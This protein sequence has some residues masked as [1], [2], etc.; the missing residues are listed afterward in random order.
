MRSLN[1]YTSTYSSSPNLYN[2][3][4]RPPR[5]LLFA[6]SPWTPQSCTAG[7]TRPPGISW[8]RI[9]TSR[10]PRLSLCTASAPLSIW[11]DTRMGTRP[12][13]SPS[14]RLAR[15]TGSSCSLTSRSKRCSADRRLLSCR[16]SCSSLRHR[17]RCIS[18]T[19][20]TL[21]ANGATGRDAER[22]G[23]TEAR[24]TAHRRTPLVRSQR[25]MGGFNLDRGEGALAA[26]SGSAVVAV[27]M[28]FLWCTAP[29]RGIGR[30]SPNPARATA[31]AR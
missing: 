19:A 4:R 6:F 27:G 5:A 30:A 2:G 29:R 17:W 21:L 18:T 24:Q 7:P 22:P 10:G 26:G 23:R 25:R 28:R 14:S 3:S 8:P 20:S 1:S 31:Q 13:S 12:T 16:L 9:G 15:R 11:R